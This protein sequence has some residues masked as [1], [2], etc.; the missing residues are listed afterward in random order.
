M[1]THKGDKRAAKILDLFTF[2]FK[3]EGPTW[4]M[5]LIFTT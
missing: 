5:P 1:L 2:E 3:G 4:C